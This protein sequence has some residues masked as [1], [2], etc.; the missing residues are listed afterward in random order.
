M[1]NFDQII[2]R[3]NTASIKWDMKD[4]FG[5]EPGYE[6]TPMWIADMDFAVLPEIQ[7][8]LKA[9]CEHPIFGYNIPTP[10]CIPALCGWYRRRH[11]WEFSEDQVIC[12]IGVVTMIRFTLEALT[13]PGDKIAVISPVY[14]PFFAQVHNTGRELVDIPMTEKDGYYSLDMNRFEEALKKGV[15]AVIFCNPQN[16]VAKIWI[17]EEL[18][19]IG[20][21]CARYGVYFLSDEVHGDIELH[22]N[23][24]TPMGLIPDVQDKLIVFTAISKSFNLAGLEQ[25]AV[26]IPNPE[27]RKKV[28]EIL[29][30]AWLMGP[31]IMAY[32]AM[33]AAYTYG[34]RWVDELNAYLSGNELYVEEE[35]RTCMPE[36][37]FAHHEG[38]FLMWL[39]MRCFGMSSTELT[40]MLARD[41][42]VGLGNG[43]NYG[44]QCDGYMRMNIAC[45]RATLEKGVQSIKRCYQEREA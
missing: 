41:Y 6:L 24:Y 8:A 29:R 11:G 44:K 5:L 43:S 42:R 37:R 36:I 26:I 22:G 35:I 32:E 1:Y 33:E 12:G 25:S 23:R 13:E 34:D 27:V 38:T 39:D 17:R 20:R 2:D 16:P 30:G 15:K 31:N 7:Q 40:K 45:P 10:G 21:L 19:E 18:E 9:R 14:D 4:V 28:N 3:R